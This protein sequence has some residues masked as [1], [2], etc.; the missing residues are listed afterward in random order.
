[1]LNLDRP[2]A[3]TGSEQDDYLRSLSSPPPGATEV[4]LD[5]L[6]INPDNPK[7]RSLAD[8]ELVESIKT[9]GLIQPLTV[10]SAEDFMRCTPHKVSAPFVIIAGHRRFAAAEKAGLRLIPVHIRSGDE[11]LILLGSIQE[12]GQRLGLTPI[13]EA[14]A[15]RA[16]LTRPG[17]EGVGQ[18]KLASLM[19]C[20]KAK[21]SRLGQLL[22]LPEVIQERIATGLMPQ[23]LALELRK[24]SPKVQELVI[25]DILQSD[26]W[27][28]DQH[29]VSVARAKQAVQGV[30]PTE[31]LEVNQ[32][33]RQAL[34]GVFFSTPAAQVPPTLLGLGVA[35][36]Q[37]Y[38]RN[39]IKILSGLP[40]TNE[41]P[42][43]SADWP[44]YL[45]SLNKTQCMR[46]AMILAVASLEADYQAGKKSAE[47]D[48]YIEW[49]KNQ[50]A[51]AAD[52]GIA[53]A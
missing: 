36:K 2:E 47:M 3:S 40:G 18:A 52:K 27:T 17:N 50:A 23:K 25:S 51:K 28:V 41:F 22:E 34:L 15:V 19:G 21:V 30:E 9:Y 33:A 39:V 31:G 1:M 14:Q 44:A 13:E 5:Q 20:N 45:A 29:T 10:V 37:G 4:A 43:K 53:D 32:K 35:S 16:F 38:N 12:N 48:C 49:L 24:L 6:A 26:R 8:P 11:V 7:G 46:A 42:K